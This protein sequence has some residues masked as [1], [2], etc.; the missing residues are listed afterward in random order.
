[1]FISLVLPKIVVGFADLPATLA[2]L[3]IFAVI[4][5]YFVAKYVDTPSQQKIEADTATTY[6]LT[7][8]PDMVVQTE[9]AEMLP[10]KI[11]TQND[12]S[13]AM[14][15]HDLSIS[16]NELLPET[17]KFISQSMP[18]STT[19]DLKQPGKN[20]ESE[21]N[22]AESDLP[23]TIAT[24]DALTGN[25]DVTKEQSVNEQPVDNV[26]VTESVDIVVDIKEKVG[27]EDETELLTISDALTQVESLS[28][29]KAV[30]ES[31][32]I[33]LLQQEEKFSN[34]SAPIQILPDAEANV[35]EFRL[36]ETDDAV[37]LV[38][39]QQI[40]EMLAINKQLVHTKVVTE[41]VDIN[42]VEGAWQEKATE[43][44]SASDLFAEEAFTVEPVEPLESKDLLEVFSNKI[45]L[46]PDYISDDIIGEKDLEQ[47]AQEDVFAIAEP[48]GVQK[49]DNF[50]LVNN[51]QITEVIHFES[52]DIDDLLEF[53]FVS[54]ESRNY[55]AALG[56]FSRALTLYPN[57]EA[58][59]FLVVEIGNIL[60]NKGAY[61]DAI[62]VFLDGRNLS[63]TQQNELMEQ[64]FISTIAYLRITKNILLQN[65]LDNI[66]FGDIPAHI[67]KQIDEQ[68]REWRTLGNI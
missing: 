51:E 47:V 45:E 63:Q 15:N 33:D 55:T 31:T 41:F 46:T 29:P 25:Q 38:E 26:V 49:N 16:Q 27:E 62:N 42:I 18:E 58:A 3:A 52:D 24:D 65:R 4:F 13:S 44:V 28:E 36:P 48:S 34:S 19:I 60:K 23:E 5:A 61:D 8:T 66:P 7:A 50:N 21:T 39:D 22:I 2:V 10:N 57:S 37:L 14:D 32:P 53:A 67:L 11:D 64:E 54:K 59:P 12:A 56:A 68:F 20:P 30:D 1:M 40:T 43:L 9:I 17:N 6:S 35:T